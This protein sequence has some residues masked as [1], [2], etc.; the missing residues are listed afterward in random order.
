MK[1]DITAGRVPR[2]PD[3]YGKHAIS[4][5]HPRSAKDYIVSRSI[6]TETG[7]WHWFANWSQSTGYGL[8]WGAEPR[9]LTKGAPNKPL[10]AHR[11]SY[12]VFVRPIPRGLVIDHVCGNRACVNPHHL[13]AVPQAVNVRRAHSGRQTC[14]NGHP[15]S[16]IVLHRAGAGRGFVSICR[17]CA[18]ERQVRH[19]WKK[20]HAA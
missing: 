18:R 4:A 2:R 5:K 3:Q 17:I 9:E 19:Y 16:E 8:Y 6:L 20:K 11:V 15:V 13:D 10:L 7:C 14:A 1:A 12:H